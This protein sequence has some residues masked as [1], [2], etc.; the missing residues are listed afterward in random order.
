MPT[1]QVANQRGKN[2]KKPG[3]NPPHSQGEERDYGTMGDIAEQ[4]TQYVSRG[5]ERMSDEM[6]E[7][8]REHEGSAL[9]VSLAA[10][11]GVGLC[12]GSMLM[13]SRRTKPTRWRDR[14][15][16]EG[17]GRRIMDRLESIV[18]EAL[19]DRLGK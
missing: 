15:T 12:L 3:G 4:A 13:S 16:A 18:P 2:F 6:R 1:N 8:T 17:I 19:A 9:F 14:M 7:C 5:Y 10:G 11:F